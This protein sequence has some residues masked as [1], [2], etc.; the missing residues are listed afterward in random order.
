MTLQEIGRD[1]PVGLVV[2]LSGDAACEKDS[3]A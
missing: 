2:G 3:Q 1:N